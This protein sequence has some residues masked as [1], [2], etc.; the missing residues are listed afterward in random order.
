MEDK[1]KCTKCGI[2]QPIENFGGGFIKSLGRFRRMSWCRTCFDQFQ[3]SWASRNVE[4]VRTKSREF[5]RRKRQSD[6]TF[7][8]RS[9]RRRRI[10]KYGLPDDWYE[11][12][13]EKQDGVCAICKQP[14]TQVGKK[15]LVWTLSLDHDHKTNQPRGLLCML[16]NHAIHKADHD[17][18]WLEAALAYLKMYD[19][20]EEKT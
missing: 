9:E 16:C 10:K 1:K 19:S 7:G 8:Q 4:R 14:E 12:Q 11:R 18:E 20:Q 2:E 17:R 5:Q 15:G 6:P 3:K 13:L